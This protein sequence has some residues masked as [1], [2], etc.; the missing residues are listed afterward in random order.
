MTLPANLKK[1]A[2]VS[3][4][5]IAAMAG[6]LIGDN[7]F[8]PFAPFLFFSIILLQFFAIIEITSLLS[9]SK[10]RHWL[11]LIILWILTFFAWYTILIPNLVL[12]NYIDFPRLAIVISFGT[13]ILTLA[14]EML[15]YDGSGSNTSRVATTVLLLLYLSVPSVSLLLIRALPEHGTAALAAT[16]FV[17]K[18]GDVSAYLIGSLIGQHTMTPTLSPKKTWEGLVGGL[19]GSILTALAIDT[20]WLSSP[21]KRGIFEA[22]FFGLVVGLAGV[23]GDLFASMIK[24][25][26]QV[27]DASQTIPGF[28]GV[29]DVVDS[30]LFAAPVAY[31]LF[32]CT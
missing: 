3:I 8:S 16:I 25:D 32:V 20:I 31:I 17:P 6:M 4:I 27:K 11:A 9:N 19:I 2:F 28:G 18:L 1:R 22:V 21:F 15:F 13:F 14:Y 24:R 7:Y 29:L 10:P 30:I 5:L 26:A 23:L 12:F